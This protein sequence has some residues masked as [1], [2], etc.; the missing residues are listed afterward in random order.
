MDMHIQRPHEGRLFELFHSVK[1]DSMKTIQQTWRQSLTAFALLAAI[2]GPDAVARETQN[3]GQPQAAAPAAPHR[4]A[5]RTF[6]VDA[7]TLV[8]ARQVDLSDYFNGSLHQGWLPSTENG[9][10]AQK[11]LPMPLG[12]TIFDGVEFNVR[13]L[14]QLSGQT[15]K[16]YGA[17]FP[18]QVPGMKVGQKCKRL[19][20]LHAAGWANYVEEGVQIGKYVLHYA[21]GSQREIPLLNG[22]NVGDWG[23]ISTENPKHAAIVWTGH[24]DTM[25]L[26]VFKT[27][28]ENPLP[29]QLIETI[30]YVS[31][32]TVASPFLI[33]ITAG[34]DEPRREPLQP[35]PVAQER[36]SGFLPVV[37]GQTLLLDDFASDTALN[38][39]LW[40]TQ[41]RV[42]GALLANYTSQWVDPTLSFGPGGMQMSGIGAENEFT[43]LASVQTYSPPLT[44]AVTVEGIIA[45]GNPFELLL[46]S[47]DLS[48][49]MSLS[50]NLNSANPPYYGIWVNYTGSGTTFHMGGDLFFSKPTTN[51]PYT[52]QLSVDEAGNGT[53]LL[54]DTNGDLLCLR[55]GLSVGTAPFYA[56]L[57]QR[58]GQP[59]TVGTNVAV[60][61]RASVVQGARKTTPAGHCTSTAQRSTTPSPTRR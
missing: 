37:A 42:L 33:A 25:D 50:G 49:R 34:S 47:S 43:G 13:G 58:E 15:I 32:M 26:R 45:N 48:S 46:V 23:G 39:S 61:H 55:T 30:D 21:D 17:N 5:V 24:N 12:V 36:G 1:G 53:A 6:K 27:T 28:W 38:T 40:T 57:A 18:E 31:D 60:W 20:F 4:L 44:L 16:G 29:D 19:H 7:N 41:S 59:N 8:A 14:V 2:H 10:A 35:E 22:D 52:I 56:V 54:A 3:Q 9:T 51:V 11:N